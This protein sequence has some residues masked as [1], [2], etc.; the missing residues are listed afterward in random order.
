MGPGEID[1]LR[2]LWRSSVQMT[3]PTGRVLRSAEEFAALDATFDE[4][5]RRY[6]EPGR[7]YH[8]LDHVRAML[9]ALPSADLPLPVQ[10]GLNLAVFL[11]DVVYDSRAKDNEERS[12]E[13]AREL[14]AS[15]GVDR[16]AREEI[17]RLIL[18]TKRHETTQ[19][20]LPGQ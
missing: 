10:A 3:L 2:K 7:H 12:A 1:S 13:Y 11:H 20:D 8:V 16:E 15:L 9:E 5:R 6:S 18:L 14:L 19:D 17:A 4:L